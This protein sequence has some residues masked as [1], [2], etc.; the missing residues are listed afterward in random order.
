MHLMVIYITGW[1]Y[2]T[3]VFVNLILEG[4][5]YLRGGSGP[6]LAWAGAKPNLNG[7]KD[8]STLIIDGNGK[9][10]VYGGN[11]K[12]TSAIGNSYS[13]GDAGG[14]V[15]NIIIKGGN[16]KAVGSNNGSG[17]GSVIYGKV[18]NLIIE[19]GIIEAIGSNC[20][21]GI[22]CSDGNAT[23][24]NIII[25][26]GKIIAQG[27]SLGAG[28]GVGTNS[29]LLKITGGNIYS[30]GSTNKRFIGA[31]IGHGMQNI[32]I[33]GGTIR[34]ESRAHAGVFKNEV[35]NVK[36]T[37]GNL[38][39]GGVGD[40]G[41]LDSSE[42]FVQG[43]STNGTDNL[44][45]TPIKLQNVGENKKVTKLTTSDNIEYGIKDMYTL[46]DGMLYLYLPAGTRTITI[47]TEDGKAYSG[48]VKTKETPE[49]VVL[50]EMN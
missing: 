24:D 41:A 9:L 50:N 19:D 21:A 5:N 37:G 44:Y 20:G 39:L 42:N 49:E 36:I 31:A 6:G 27:G 15:N 8:G 34:T 26:G 45:K 3:G 25:N 11:M 10:E 46:E 32:L 33:E 47:I 14:E 35:N 13:G 4:N 23:A 40:I 16:I 30:I 38:Q 48:T 7:V 28:I 43:I 1:H 29:G 2:E 22:G 18:N 12:W 17:I